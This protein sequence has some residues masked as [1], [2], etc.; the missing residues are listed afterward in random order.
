MKKKLCYYHKKI[1]Q[2]TPYVNNIHC[3][4]LVDKY[5][6][7]HHSLEK[8]LAKFIASYD[9]KTSKECGHDK[10][11]SWVSF[12]FHKDPKNH[13]RKLLFCSIIFANQKLI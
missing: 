1:T 9:S 10:I 3:K 5:K 6:E 7:R 2:F 12:N 4:S 8:K 13:Y 11:I